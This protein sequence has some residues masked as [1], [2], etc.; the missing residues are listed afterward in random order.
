MHTEDGF[1]LIELIAVVVIIGIVV[2]LAIPSLLASRRVANEVSAVNTLRAY[3]S[4]ETT[5]HST[6]G[7]SVSYGNESD[8]AGI[9][10]SVLATDDPTK[11][12]YHFGLEIGGTGNGLYCVT[13]RPNTPGATGSRVFAISQEGVIYASASYDGS[14][15]PSA[16]SCASGALSVNGAQPI[17]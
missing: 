16:P 2:A 10:D 7:G 13:A 14:V 5:Y 4:A 17:Q 3:H 1:S 8:L 6:T 9:V 15:Y 11:S 12:G